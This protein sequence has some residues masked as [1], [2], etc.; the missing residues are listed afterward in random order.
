MLSADVHAERT[1]CLEMQRRMPRMRQVG[2]SCGSTCLAMALEYHGFPSK[3][4]TIEAYIH[5]YGNIDLGEVPAELARYA[6]MVGFAACHYNHGSL[7]T[8]SAHISRGHTVIVMLNYRNGMGHI[9]NV[10]GMRRSGEGEVVE[11]LI[12]NPWGFD[13]CIAADRFF[14]EW[15]QMRLTR[16]SAARMLPVFDRAY[17]VIAP[18]SEELPP[19]SAT[20]WLHSAPVNLLVASMNGIGASV[21]TIRNGH[22]LAGGL[23]LLGYA[24]RFVGGLLSYVVGNIVGKNMEFDF[25]SATTTAIGAHEVDIVR[26]STTSSVA[27]CGRYTIRLSGWSLSMLGGAIAG[28]V[29]LTTMPFVMPGGLLA[30]RRDIV[31]EHIESAD[32]DRLR[33]VLEVSNV[34]A[35]ANQVWALVQ[36][37]C[38][39]VSESDRTA[40]SRI[41]RLSPH[42]QKLAQMCDSRV[43]V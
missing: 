15:R 27:G 14:R 6:R 28:T 17:V 30:S 16:K 32:D 8:L 20:S 36:G 2:P 29:E 19:I 7:E 3:L 39:R 41:L 18:P 31:R 1:A 10:L 12:R 25:A 24:V 37:G 13:E 23:Q 4:E 21:K 35:S 43:K 11:V 42:G 38:G 9:V 26:H 40:A 5:P 34:S 33:R 22:L